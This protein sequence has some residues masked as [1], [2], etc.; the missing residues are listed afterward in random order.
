MVRVKK[1][2]KPII[3]KERKKNKKRFA[4]TRFKDLAIP[5]RPFYRLLKDIMEENQRINKDAVEIIQRISEDYIIDLFDWAKYLA[6]HRKRKTVQ[7]RDLNLARYLKS[8]L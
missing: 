6:E 7:I 2:R 8:R 4:V 3:R 5:K 1:V